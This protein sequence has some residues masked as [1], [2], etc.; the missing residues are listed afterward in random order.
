[1]IW[2]LW[3]LSY[4]INSSTCMSSLK[5]TFIFNYD[6]YHLTLSSF[7]QNHLKQLYKT[8]QKHKISL[9]NILLSNGNKTAK[10]RNERQG[11]FKVIS[12]WVIMCCIFFPVIKQPSWISWVHVSVLSLVSTQSAIG[13]TTPNISPCH[14]CY[15]DYNIFMYTLNKCSS[16]AQN[17]FFFVFFYFLR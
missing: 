1:M 3:I 14:D 16:T 15:C 6:I 9:P 8:I 2:K 7:L 13:S 5:C 11:L 4:C 10:M 17:C 12:L